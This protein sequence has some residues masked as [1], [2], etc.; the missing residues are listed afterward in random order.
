MLENDNAFWSLYIDNQKLVTNN[1]YEYCSNILQKILKDIYI[2]DTSKNFFV[3]EIY[4][5]EFILYSYPKNFPTSYT[6]EELHAII[7]NE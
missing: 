3:N 7:Q 4:E 6:K 5:N 2:N 1:T